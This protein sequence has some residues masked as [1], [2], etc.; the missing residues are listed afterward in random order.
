MSNLLESAKNYLA[1]GLSVIATDQNKRAVFPWKKFQSELPTSEDLVQQFAHDK[2]TGVAIICGAVS[3]GLEVI[4]LDLKYDLTGS[5]YQRVME[6]I[7][8]NDLFKFLYIV[9]TKSG[10][11]HFYYRCECIEGNQKLA[12]RPTTDEERAVNP[13]DKVRVLLETRGEGGYVCAPGTECYTHKHGDDIKV[14]SIDQRETL[15]TICRSFNEIV[16][17]VP[18]NHSSAGAPSER[19]S[20]S[21]WEDYNARGDLFDLLKKHGWAVLQQRGERVLLRRPGKDEGTSGDFHTGLNLFKIFT[22]STIFESGK[23]YKPAAVYA[24]LECNGDFRAAA[25]QLSEAGYGL[26]LAN[27]GHKLEREV[28]GRKKDGQP[29]EEIARA[30]AKGHNI[31]EE[32]AEAAVNELE[33]SWGPDIEEFWDVDDKGKITINR[34]K[35]EQFLSKRGGFHLYFYDKNS[36]IYRLVQVQDM[37]VEEVSTE[38]VKKFIKSYVESLPEKFDNG[39]TPGDLLEVIY[40]GSETYFSKG[41]LEFISRIDL[42]FLKDTKATAYYPFRNGIVMVTNNIISLKPYNEIGKHIWQSQVIDFK[43]DIMPDFDCTLCE[44]FRFIQCVCNQEQPRVEYA[45]TMIGYLLHKH[46]DPTRPYATILAEETEHESKGGG[47]GKGIFVKALTYLLNTV[48]VDGK[49]FKLDK[50]FAFQRVGLDTRLLC[51]EDVRKNVDFEG[52]YSMIT[53]GVTVEKKN[54]DELFIPYEDSPKILFTTNYSISQSG[55][56]ARRRQ[57]VFEFSSFFTLEKTPEDHFGHK[58]FDDWDNDEWNRFYNLL[59]LCVNLYMEQGIMAHDNGLKLKRKHIKLHYTEEFLEYFDDWNGGQWTMFHD[60]YSSFLKSNDFDKKDYSQKR[61]KKAIQ[62]SGELFGI[63]IEERKNR[64]ANNLKELKKSVTE[65]I[66]GV[67]TSITGV[68]TLIENGVK[69]Y[70]LNGVEGKK[71]ELPF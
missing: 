67:E 24:I 68:G 57:R 55:N 27:Y 7:V 39:K 40:K 4:D 6:E 50:N 35:L 47:T 29:K 60:L 56:H 42:D 71:E 17:Q 65:S 5:L 33:Q 61:F 25:R 52:F 62:E 41:F 13:T 19:Y 31:S 3:A 58:L 48:R 54:K 9:E 32:Q 37:F 20:L 59:F 1:R 63:I 69:G 46:K 10:G 18:F 12:Q 8:N 16:E 51:I 2:A 21:P 14:L 64:Q 66:T 34:R 15:L 44:Y 53:E 23:G 36:T 22:T 45:M 70:G 30:I 26:R 28:Y 11:Y 38:Q 43:I 49:N